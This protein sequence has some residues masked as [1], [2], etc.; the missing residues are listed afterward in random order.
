MAGTKEL[1]EVTEQLQLLAERRENTLRKVLAA[2]VVFSAIISTLGIVY[3]ADALVH[4]SAGATNS[5]IRLLDVSLFMTV[6][7]AIALIL[8]GNRLIARK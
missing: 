1:P 6:F 5:E 2:C 7:G 4:V 3:L 8:C